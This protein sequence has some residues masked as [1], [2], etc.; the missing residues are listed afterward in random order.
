MLVVKRYWFD[1]KFG[2]KMAEAMLTVFMNEQQEYKI[3]IEGVKGHFWESEYVPRDEFGEFD[4]EDA[5][6][7]FRHGMSDIESFREAERRSA[8]V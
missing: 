2:Y 1:Y 8:F 5:I 3:E 7:S 6:E 4:E